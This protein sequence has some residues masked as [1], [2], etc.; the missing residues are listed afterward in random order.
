VLYSIT[1]TAEALSDHVIRTQNFL[2]SYHTNV[3]AYQD[4]VTSAF[5]LA[6]AAYFAC[7]NDNNRIREQFGLENVRTIDFIPAGYEHI[8]LFP[9][10]KPSTRPQSIGSYEEFF[11]AES[12]DEEDESDYASDDSSFMDDLAS[13][14]L[15]TLNVNDGYTD[16]E[17]EDH[18]PDV[19]RKLTLDQETTPKASSLPTPGSDS[20]QK[21]LSIKRRTKL[22]HPTVSMESVSLMSIMRNNVRLEI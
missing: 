15:K 5:Q 9:S 17:E 4:T 10:L 6:E 16:D 21:L 2:D 20:G 3:I 1:S 7:L 11:D 8:D 12:G 19:N 18:S 14:K 13:S 22:P